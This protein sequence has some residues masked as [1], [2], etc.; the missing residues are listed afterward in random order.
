MIDALLE[1]RRLQA[2]E[3]CLFAERIVFLPKERDNNRNNSYKHLGRCWIETANINKEFESEIIYRQIKRHNRTI[4]EE[5]LPAP[6]RRLRE[7]YVSVEP[8]PCEQRNREDDTQS[9]N[10]RREGYKTQ[11][12]HLLLKHKVI[13]KEIQHPIKHQITYSTNSITEK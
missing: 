10:M 9:S 5:L 3:V 7:R 11:I 2:K 4:A 6:N 1:E 12:N 13:D 8:K